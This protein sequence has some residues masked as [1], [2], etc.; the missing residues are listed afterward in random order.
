MECINVHDF[1]FVSDFDRINVRACASVRTREPPR[2]R[3][4]CFIICY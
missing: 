2:P 3:I 1:G 4:F